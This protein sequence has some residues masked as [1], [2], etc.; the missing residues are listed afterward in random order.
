MSGRKVSRRVSTVPIR[1]PKEEGFVAADAFD[2]DKEFRSPKGVMTRARRSSVVL[3]KPPLQLKTNR[4]KSMMPTVAEKPAKALNKR[5]SLAQEL[6]SKPAPKSAYK[7]IELKNFYESPVN[8]PK[9][10]AGKNTSRVNNID[11]ETVRKS[12]QLA[13]SPVKKVAPHAKNIL[14]DNAILQSLDS[15]MESPEIVQKTVKTPAINK[16]KSTAKTP[17]LVVTP[18]SARSPPASTRRATRKTPAPLKKMSVKSPQFA[19]SPNNTPVKTPKSAKKTTVPKK[20]PALAKST[21]KAAPK[22]TKKAG[23]SDSLAGEVREVTI[24]LR[25]LD[26]GIHADPQVLLSQLKSLPA[27]PERVDQV[28][29]KILSAR[30]SRKRKSDDS[31][32][33]DEVGP[34]KKPRMH[35]K[36]PAKSAKKTPAKVAS[37]NKSVTT[38]K[39]PVLV[40]KKTLMS[41]KKTPGVRRAMARTAG[42]L[43]STPVQINPAG[44]LKRNLRTKVETAIETKMAQKPDSSPYI[45][46]QDGENSP[47]FEKM[48]KSPEAKDVI[49]THITGTPAVARRTRKF[50][51]TIQPSMLAA[52]SPV[53]M[54]TRRM[55]STP[56]RGKRTMPA[57]SA[58]IVNSTPIRAP[59][60]EIPE[61]PEMPMSPPGMEVTGKLGKL[62]SIM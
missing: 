50:G 49:K 46:N 53:P 25:A 31:E 23:K 60:D 54:T 10:S 26:A 57:P 4:R 18:K 14:S 59:A 7:G 1:K 27:S 12:L 41:A 62:C 40:A 16:K 38:Q 39:R 8:S 56:M 34:N 17:K 58:D 13:A 15:L 55:S 32:S 47:K 5:K 33:V 19:K 30:T 43:V 37:A 22:S 24:K 61:S 21:K 11:Y 44:M 52:D 42:P 6:K 20:T 51:T 9:T 3:S 48:S 36:T 35:E 2:F 29:E 28:V 45:L